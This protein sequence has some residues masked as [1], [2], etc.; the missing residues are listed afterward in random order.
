MHLLQDENSQE[1]VRSFTIVQK[2]RLIPKPGTS[3]I[4]VLPSGS[5][6]SMCPAGTVLLDCIA[7]LPSFTVLFPEVLCALHVG[8]ACTWSSLTGRAA[9]KGVVPQGPAVQPAAES[10]P[11]RQQD[12]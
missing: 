4:A 1:Y 2:S 6:R 10:E 8:S 12:R 5:C 11:R 7:Q 9:A 3:P